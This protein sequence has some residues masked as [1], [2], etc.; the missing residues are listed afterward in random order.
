MPKLGLP[1]EEPGQAR[2]RAVR[3]PQKR[4]SGAWKVAYADFVT[5]LMAL[6][7]VL[8]MMSASETVKHSVQGYFRDPRGYTK[9]LGAGVANQGEGLPVDHKSV[10][11]VQRR[12]EE[13]MRRMPNFSRLEKNIVVSVTGEGLRIDL[14]ESEQGLFFVTGSPRPTPAGE[15][16]L[17]VLA[18]ELKRMP[19]LLVVEGHT[20]SRPF[21]NTDLSDLADNWELSASRANAARRLL[22]ATGV[23]A[24][25]VVELRGFA[26]QRLFNAADPND[27]RNR[28]VSVVVKFQEGG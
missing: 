10:T 21:R 15:R 26:D 9:T 18:G 4:R 20:D 1:Q 22:E 28:R 27:S 19:N 7:I 16:L 8:W 11:S 24:G 12:I 23:R 14:L 25:Q 5:A 13:A 6:F 3:L 17:T 2:P